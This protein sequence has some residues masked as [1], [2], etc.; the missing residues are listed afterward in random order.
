[1]DLWDEPFSWSRCSEI[2]FIFHDRKNIFQT[3]Q[4]VKM[5]K[6]RGFLEILSFIILHTP[7]NMAEGISGMGGFGTGAMG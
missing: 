1:M 2:N 7:L 4:K 3:F 6:F 5:S